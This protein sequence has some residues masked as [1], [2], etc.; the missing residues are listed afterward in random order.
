MDFP[1]SAD[2][3]PTSLPGLP[4]N[5]YSDLASSLDLS[6]SDIVEGLADNITFSSD[7][8]SYRG[9]LVHLILGEKWGHRDIQ[10]KV[11]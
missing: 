4:D 3:G 9:C 8:V 1:G 11:K 6:A 2:C 7:C 5:S 10:M